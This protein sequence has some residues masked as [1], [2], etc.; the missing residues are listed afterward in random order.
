MDCLEVEEARIRGEVLGED[1]RRHAEGCPVCSAGG[2]EPL[3]AGDWFTRVEAD[4]SGERGLVARLRALPTRMR[5]VL[6]LMVIVAIAGAMVG[7]APRSRF[8]PF[9]LERM[10]L[11]APV[12]A[13]LAIAL[14]RLALRPLQEPAASRR[15]IAVALGM[16]LGVPVLFALLPTVPPL[17]A[18]PGI[19]PE[20]ATR[21]CFA[22][23]AMVGLLV[24]VA[25]RALDRGSS[26]SFSLLIAAGAGGVA[27]SLA[28]EL[29]CPITAASHLLLGH[30]SVGVVLVAA[31]AL[32]VARR[33]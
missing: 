27:A 1:A 8:A 11:V 3:P 31:G 9:P 28:L 13:V 23:G 2:R 30:A 29:H 21:V 7:L 26:P 24:L 16:A 33:R 14:A 22:A 19:P 17:V 6:L 5:L 32:F 12:L 10:A 18:V 20:V 25:L 4:I 15:W